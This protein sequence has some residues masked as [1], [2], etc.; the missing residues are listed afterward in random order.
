MTLYTQINLF[1]RAH[2]S[3]V[4]S[5]GTGQVPQQDVSP[6]QVA[7]VLT[8]QSGTAADQA[9]RSYSL[10]DTLSGSEVLSLDLSSG[11]GLVDAFG[12]ALAFARVKLAY[13]ENTG[14]A[15]APDLLIGGTLGIVKSG[16]FLRPGECLLRAVGDATA[17]PVVN[18]SSDSLTVT[19]TSNSDAAEV[20]L[21]LVGSSA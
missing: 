9:D 17:Y 20:R 2:A 3:K 5:M 14:A 11:G 19:N 18:A 6:Q 13:I 7:K 8:W 4:T 15:G 1:L 16:Q 10:A 12:A 21:L